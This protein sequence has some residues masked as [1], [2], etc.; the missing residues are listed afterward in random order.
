MQNSSD[1][2]KYYEI[3]G[4]TPD[5]DISLLKKQY[6]K[7]AKFWH[8]DHNTAPEAIETFQKLSIAYDVLKDD[9]S[10]LYYDLLS[11]VYN[12]ND[13]PDIA[14]MSPFL[15]SANK[16]DLNIRK[17]HIYTVTGQI[18]KTKAQK[19]I[20]MMTFAEAK[21]CLRKTALKNWLFGWW[22]LSGISKNLKALSSNLNVFENAKRDNLKLFIH[23]MIALNEE[24]KPGF[25]CMLANLAKSYTSSENENILLDKFIA[26][27]GVYPDKRLPEWNYKQLKSVQLLI[28]ALLA[29]FLLIA[30]CSVIFSPSIF[31]SKH[32][33]INYNHTVRGMAGNN[34]FDD[35]VVGRIVDIPVDTSDLSK[36]CHLKSDAKIMYGP[37]DK[38]DV[39]KELKAGH[40]LRITGYTPDN[41]WYRVMLDSGEDGFVRAKAV[42]KGIGNEIPANSKISQ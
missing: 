9:K 14:T 16:L 34:T 25:A 1:A 3:L 18:I 32:H 41:V 10:R 22:S 11:L 37:D 38:F 24:R 20:K 7:L 30:T 15:N 2:K 13:F 17:V 5:A 21:N 8:P 19:I 33:E 23:N 36:L 27:T 4:V 39:L 35:M 26:L 12:E 31:P 28:P 42:I 29:F 40:T 6:F